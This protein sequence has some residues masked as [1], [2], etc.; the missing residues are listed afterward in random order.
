[1]MDGMQEPNTNQTGQPGIAPYVPG[2]PGM[3]TGSDS[4][5]QILWRGRWLILFSILLAAGG[6]YVY[7]REAVPMYQST[8][9]LLVDKP[10]P[11]T[12]SDVPQPVGSTLTNYLATQAGMIT[13]PEIIVAALRDPNVLALPTFSDPNYVKDLIGS[14]SAE[15]AKKADI[16]QITASSAYPE[17]AA[18]IVNAVVRA[19]IRWHETNRQLTT[20][21]L[22][23]DLN[24]QLDNRYRELQLKRKEQML[25]EQRHPEV[26]EN[27][28]GG[29]ISKAVEVLR[30]ELT[31]TRLKVVERDAY[32]QGLQRLKEDPNAVRKY[33]YSHQTS[34]ASATVSATMAASEYSDRV[35][36][37]EELRQTQW[38]LADSQ[39]VAAAR[40]SL[41]TVLQ[42][43]QRELE[44]KIADL[45]TGYVQQHVALAK[46]LLDEARTQEQ[47]I[48]EM[49]EKEF[50]KVQSLSDQDSQY[51]FLKSECEMMEKLCNSLLTQISQLDLSARLEGLKIYVLQRAIP[52]EKPSSPQAVKIIGIAL[53]LGLMAGAGLSLLRDWRDQRVRSPD[54]ITAIV[55]APILGAIPSISRRAL[56]RGQRLRFASNSRESE[57]CLAIRTSLL[58][59]AHRDQTRTIL[60]TSPGPRE[61]KTL[62]VTN[63]GMAMAQAGQKTLIVDADLRKPVKQRVFTM[64]G[65]S[66]GL[67]DVLAGT[68]GLREA[69]RLTD[70][71]RLDVLEGGRSTS[72][73]SELLNGPAFAAVLEQL[74]S[75]YD[76]ILIDSPPVGLVTDAQIL[77]TLCDST[78]LVLRADESSR[79]LTQRARDALLAVG[80]R[81]DGVIVNDVS[82]RN[83]R[84]GYYSGYGYYH[85]PHGSNNY[86]AIRKELPD[87]RTVGQSD[88]RTVRPSDGN[89]GPQPENA[90]PAVEKE[91]ENV[92]G[93]S[94][95]PAVEP[96]TGTL[97][98]PIQEYEGRTARKEPSDRKTVGRSDGQTAKQSD[99][100]TVGQ[101]DRDGDPDPAINSPVPASEKKRNGR[102]AA[103]NGLATNGDLRPE[104]GA[105]APEKAQDS[106]PAG[107]EELRTDPDPSPAH[108]VVTVEKK[109]N[110]RKATSGGQPADAGLTANG[111]A[112]R[113][114]QGNGGK[115][116]GPQQQAD[117]GPQPGGV[118]EIPEKKR[119]GRQATA[120]GLPPVPGTQPHN[121][122]AVPER[123]KN[124]DQA[125][126][127]RRPAE[128]GP[129]PDATALAAQRWKRWL[130]GN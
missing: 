113:P 25:F 75:Q 107:A 65:H 6:A 13:S 129:S 20:A 58:C 67:V 122:A 93:Q 10:N 96:K 114:Q 51:A 90:T 27:T 4:L 59:G 66:I 81:V 121:G 31:S 116:T 126:G 99:S 124:G 78:V 44:K 40:S 123:E 48:A 22:L 91:K 3:G 55:G 18:R 34:S 62:L 57:A 12:R 127:Q 104:D 71:D 80:A 92:A 52:A 11:Q 33:V 61:G 15:V 70:I 9:Q 106:R 38:R 110:G 39:A 79:I 112:T 64:N 88:G 94:D 36:F 69:I 35:R 97:P 119:N 46:I 1:M 47:K 89:A 85:S 87:S 56:R 43:R 125:D 60:V 32:Y 105:W 7:L 54:E 29:M 74:K 2:M 83:T 19:Y 30:D 50:A 8:S 117:G 41:V 73:P 23:K 49:Y 120:H 68:T 109:K 86:T 5:F 63:L 76:R 130:Q 100:R 128:P 37:Q 14:L 102:K 108:A 101:S 98:V 95:S 111:S 82:R 118:A 24:G 17:D 72:N 21:D 28:P 45:D 103:S 115:A 16:I 84:Y 77:A 26:V 53:V 42:D